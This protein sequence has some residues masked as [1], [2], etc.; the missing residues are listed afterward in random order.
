MVDS[1]A[2]LAPSKD[3]ESVANLAEF[4]TLEEVVAKMGVSLSTVKLRILQG[5]LHPV[6]GRRSDEFGRQRNYQRLFFN[7]AE[8][9]SEIQRAEDIRSR[10]KAY[11]G[12]GYLMK[13]KP[14]SGV[15]SHHNKAPEKIPTALVKSTIITDGEVCAAALKIFEAGGTQL[16]VIRDLKVDFQAAKYFWGCYLEAQP[17]WFLPSKEFAR[18]R[19]VLNW[20]EDPPTV[21]G[22]SRAFSRLMNAPNP[23]T[24]A[25]TSS[26][27]NAIE[28]ALANPVDDT[29]EE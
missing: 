16:T 11:V 26:E 17:G 9:E 2:A 8:V 20:T 6:K 4:Y 12:S 24:K 23:E 3:E 1:S 29:D 14:S 22:F 15:G 19:S 10:R 5:Y 27:D 21:G 25:L 13:P 18:I 7:P 28:A